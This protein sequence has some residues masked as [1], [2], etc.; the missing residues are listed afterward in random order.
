M[1]RDRF[2]LELLPEDHQIL[3]ELSEQL[4]ATRTEILRWALRYYAVAGPWVDAGA[5]KVPCIRGRESVLVIGPAVWR[6]AS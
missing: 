3:K 5:G 6:P 1:G 2:P 4:Y